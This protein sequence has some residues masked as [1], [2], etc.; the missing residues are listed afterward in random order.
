MKNWIFILGFFLN[1]GVDAL[2][3]AILCSEFEIF[4]T[5]FEPINKDILP[6]DLLTSNKIQQ[7]KPNELQDL[8]S[9]LA[10]LEYAL[11][12]QSEEN[13]SFIAQTN[14]LA[15]F[16]NELRMFLEANPLTNRN[17]YYLARKNIYDANEKMKLKDKK[18]K[19]EIREEIDKSK[20]SIIAPR[21]IYSSKESRRFYRALLSEDG[22]Y[23]IVLFDGDEIEVR[24]ISSNRVIYRQSFQTRIN[25][26]QVV[27][28]KNI[29][30][31]SRFDDTTNK[32]RFD[33]VDV[34][35]N[36]V[37]HSFANNKLIFKN[38][39]SPNGRFFHT[40]ES[41]NTIDVREFP[42]GKVLFRVRHRAQIEYMSF[43][44]D[45]LY[46][47][48]A[49]KDGKVKLSILSSGQTIDSFNLQP[50]DLPLGRGTDVSF[51][52]DGTTMIFN[53]RK[54]I[55]L[56]NFKLHTN[57][58][59]IEHKNKVMMFTTNA[60]G[61][62]LI[63]G[64]V[65]P[66]TVIIRKPNINFEHSYNLT[67]EFQISHLMTTFVDGKEV[68]ISADVWGSLEV[69][70][71]E[72]MEIISSVMH[73]GAIYSI[74]L[75]P[76]MHYLISAGSDKVVRIT[77]L[78]N[79]LLVHTIEHP[80]PVFYLSISDGGRYLVSISNTIKITDLFSLP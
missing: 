62:T 68:L 58:E 10:R 20:I 26:L 2:A 59:T 22:L 38:S 67:P 6:L 30:A 34:K 7:L 37:T 42:S 77:D 72:S 75:V 39:F 45:N 41:R 3:H 32:G 71:L 48:T 35:S 63:T 49:S 11:T 69:R 12:H 51:H 60:D 79:N 21:E 76:G 18:P 54:N 66:S 57:V 78:K 27:D 23:L 13:K 50:E 56:R 5:Q 36:T 31:T 44:K 43:S 29:I 24:D 74:F 61:N 65:N 28:G 17:L 40:T 1:Y 80:Q 4:E 14:M 33:L 46:L 70:D 9:D 16:N 8:A 47:V 73:I 25:N 64:Y 55:F 19:K 52:S 15:H 53:T